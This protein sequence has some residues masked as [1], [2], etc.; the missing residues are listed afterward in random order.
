[1]YE[2]G[3]RGCRRRD[4][5]WVSGFSLS[6]MWLDIPVMIGFALVLVP[7][8][9]MG[10]KITRANGVLLL[11]AYAAYVAYLLHIAGG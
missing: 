3:V 8:M 7:M 6:L 11:V 10:L 5:L 9:L 4:R 2:I 1:M